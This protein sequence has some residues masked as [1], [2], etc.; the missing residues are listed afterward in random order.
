MQKYFSRFFHYILDGSSFL[1]KHF[2]HWSQW[3]NSL[4]CH[5]SLHLISI[6]CKFPFHKKHHH[7]CHYFIKRNIYILSGERGQSLLIITLTLL[8]FTSFKIAITHI[9]LP[10]VYGCAQLMPLYQCYSCFL[11]RYSYGVWGPGMDPKFPDGGFYWLPIDLFS[12]IKSYYKIKT[13]S[14]SIKMIKIE[15]KSG[16]LHLPFWIRIP[17]QIPTQTN[18]LHLQIPVLFN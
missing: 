3:L 2:I 18:A 4:H 1:Y 16:N 8:I 6:L 9:R 14:K 13:P 17:P 10:S 11:I 15:H 7:C 12:K 5:Y